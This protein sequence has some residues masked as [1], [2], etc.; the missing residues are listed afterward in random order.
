MYTLYNG[1]HVIAAHELV[2]MIGCN[3]TWLAWALWVCGL[4]EGLRES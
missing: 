3:T 1:Q 2:H 4:D